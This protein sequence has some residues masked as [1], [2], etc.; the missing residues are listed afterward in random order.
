MLDFDFQGNG[1]RPILL[2]LACQ[3]GLVGQAVSVVAAFHLAQ[4]IPSMHAA[5]ERSQELILSRLRQQSLR[6]DPRTF[7]SLS[8]WA[9]I[10]VLLVGDTITGSSNYVYL[11]QLLSRLAQSAADDASLSD[12]TKA[13]VAEQTKMLA[14][15]LFCHGFL[16]APPPPL[17][18]SSLPLPSS[19]L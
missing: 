2:P 1:Y 18:P 5:A 6:L 11:L 10:L 14:T 4:K 3:N 16:P 8:T 19:S 15:R 12:A 17:T 7:C 13:F 9:T